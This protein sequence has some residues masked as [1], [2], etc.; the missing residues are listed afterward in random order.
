MRLVENLK[1]QIIR[2]NNPSNVLTSTQWVKDEQGKRLI[3]RAEAVRPH[4]VG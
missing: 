4:I 1:Q 2:L 3:E